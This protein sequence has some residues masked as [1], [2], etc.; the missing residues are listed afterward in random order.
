M[1]SLRRQLICMWQALLPLARPL[2]RSEDM[3]LKA[4]GRLPFRFLSLSR[5]RSCNLS[6]FL[7]LR[8]LYKQ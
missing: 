8:L 5:F 2:L 4:V 6:L 3:S 7:L 1:L